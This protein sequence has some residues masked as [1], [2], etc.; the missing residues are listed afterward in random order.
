MITSLS[1]QQA[2]RQRK[3]SIISLVNDTEAVEI[4][5]FFFCVMASGVGFRFCWSAMASSSVG[6]G[7]ALV[8]YA[9]AVSDQK[10]MIVVSAVNVA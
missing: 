6:Y 4:Y 10:K 3:Q 5:R 9:C 2:V 1:Y 7:S 8:C